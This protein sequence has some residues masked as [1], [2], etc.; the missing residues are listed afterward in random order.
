MQHRKTSFTT[1]AKATCLDRKHKRR[2]DLQKITKTIKKAVLGSYLLILT[3]NGNGLNAPPKRQTGWVDET[4]CRGAL[5]L[6]T[7]L[8]LTT[9]HVV[10]NYFIL[11]IMFPLWLAIIIIFSFL[12]GYWLGKLIN[13]FYYGDDVTITHFTPLYHDWSTET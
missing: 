10:C 7:S 5:P 8:T 2:K 13:I 12:S 11:L 3:L 4:V 6:P 1:N 9:P